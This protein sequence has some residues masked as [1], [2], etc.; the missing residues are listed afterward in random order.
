MTIRKSYIIALFFCCAIG[1]NVLNA[2][3]NINQDVKVVK[4]YTPTISDAYKVNYMPELNDSTTISPAFNYRIL[5]TSASTN[6]EPAP[7]SPAKI[8]FKRKEHLNS[9]Y[10]KG[11]IG[12]YSSLLAELGYNVLENE[13]Y[14]LGFNIGHISSFG[15]LTLENEQ[16]VE[17]PFHDTWA[18]ADFKHFFDDKTFGIELGFNRSKYQYYGYQTLV[19]DELYL[20]NDGQVALGSDLS[21]AVDQRLSGFDVTASLMNNETDDRKTK[22]S[23]FGGFNAFGSLTGVSQMGFKLGGQL[24]YPVNDLGIKVDGE[25]KSF[26]TKVPTATDVMYSF[27]D[28]SHTL[29]RVN[30]GVVFNF[31]RA[32]IQVGV[33]MAGFIDTEGDEFYVTPDVLGELTVVEGIATVYGGITGRVGMNDYQSVLNENAFAAADV[34]VKSSIYGVNFLAGIKGNFSSAT[35]FSLGMEYGFFNN[36][37]FWVNR[38]YALQTPPVDQAG[39]HYSNVFDVVYDDG[40][41]LKVAGEILYKPKP[42]M[43]FLLNGAYY[44][45]N[46]D[47]LEKAWH[48]PE[49]EI[50]VEGRFNVLDNLFAKAGV[51]YLGDRWAMDVSNI[52]LSKKLGG[53]VDVNLGAEY[54][55]SKQWSFWA[56]INNMA[57]AKYYKWNGYPTQRFSAKAG[58]IFSF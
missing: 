55:F 45:W 33:M 2:Q 23:A 21:P 52:D 46:L 41:L 57:A 51:T 28:R 10:L 37:H 39:M 43:E 14:L 8:S 34:N 48:K 3:E 16:S 47:G 22:Y 49:V 54:F 1:H 40:S 13:K 20:D 6:Y 29:I 26:S 19:S 24:L 38:S 58:I 35:S 18:S 12:N 31:D 17:A 36:E 44:G 32:S 11:G 56:T 7:I 50:G 42:N 27:K 4:A 30:P 25:V 5:S 9:S 53:V 15:E